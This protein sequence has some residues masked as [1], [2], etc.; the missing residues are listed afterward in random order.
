MQ[1][2]NKCDE[3]W[4]IVSWKYH[5]CLTYKYY[6]VLT[7]SRFEICEISTVYIIVKTEYITND[8][9]KSYAYLRHFALV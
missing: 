4:V 2:N 5:W 7:K 3:P 9:T 1:L 8:N 6:V